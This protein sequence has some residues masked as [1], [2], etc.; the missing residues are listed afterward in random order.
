VSSEPKITD[1]STSD[2]SS[3]RWSWTTKLIV[4]LGLV[5][6]AIWL[7]VQFQNFLGPVIL[8][9]ILAYLFYPIANFIRTTLKL[10]WR[11]SVTLIYL[12]I[13]L[14]L[15][16][17]LTWGGLTL[18][19]QIQNLI[20]F[21]QN[22]I[23]QIPGMIEDFSQQT[24]TIGPWSFSFEGLGWDQITTEIIGT[25]R[26]A[27]GQLGSLAGSLATGAANV[28]LWIGV[29]L[30]VSYFLLAETEGISNRFLTIRIPG[31]TADLRRMGQELGKIWNA[32]L[33]GQLIVVLITVIIYTSYLG[34]MGIQFFFGLALVAAIG[35]FIPYV[36]AWITWITY[37]LVA[38]LQ[39]TTIFNL[40]PGIY[41]IILLGGAMLI[42]TLLDNLLVPK[43][44]S[45]NL[46]VHPALVL[47]GALIAVNLL[48]LIGILL[49]APVLATLKLIFGYMTKK[50]VDQD[51]WE[52]LDAVEP[53]ER[54]KWA[55]FVDE[56]W[57]RFKDWFSAFAKRVGE[58]LNIQF[59]KIGR[60]FK[61]KGKEVTKKVR[62]RK[63]KPK[64][65]QK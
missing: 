3:P 44:M 61:A 10:P 33:R 17:L 38:L 6:I 51:P 8:A 27:I 42:D 25:V 30:L 43:V 2:Q 58:W 11:L 34:L 23:D 60:F 20:D 28:V 35:R 14:A 46:K 65:D 62:N 7:L 39:G 18:A 56:Q 9:F 13:V 1:K 16:G 41:A 40:S 63:R 49:A 48:G 54:A 47:V 36:G 26:P 19:D 4:G 37:G 59:A 15:I 55:V 29:V 45:E 5:A 12:I 50:L 32:F 53:K 64:K 22:N 52:E 57:D 24:Y 21:I 31:Y